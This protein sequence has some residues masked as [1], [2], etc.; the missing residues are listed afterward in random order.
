M[1]GIARPPLAP[2]AARCVACLS[3]ML[4]RFSIILTL[5]ATALPAA[6]LN[7]ELFERLE[8]RYIGPASMGGRITSI[9]VSPGNPAMV[10][11]ATASGGLFKTVNAGTS[12]TPIFDHQNTISI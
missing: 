3:T 10:Y 6:D 12:W 5:A 7:S 11:V 9:A 8:W 4:C 1:E 2:P